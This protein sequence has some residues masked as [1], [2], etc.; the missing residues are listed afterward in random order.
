MKPGG[1]DGGTKLFFG[2]IILLIIGLYLFLDSVQVTSG[3]YGLFSGMIGGGRQGF[4]TGSMGIVFVPF[5]IGVG[6]LFYSARSRWAWLLSG[7]G[8][9]IIIVEILSRIRFVMHI[10]TSH[11]MIMLVMMA[12]GAGLMARGLLSEDA[13]EKTKKE[14]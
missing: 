13:K 12:A 10:K 14:E 11:L 7:A 9:V 8:L 5:I 1:T 3:Q 2:G 4:E 6:G